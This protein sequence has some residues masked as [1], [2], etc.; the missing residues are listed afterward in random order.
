VIVGRWGEVPVCWCISSQGSTSH[1]VS[2]REECERLEE[3]V[4]SR[5]W[6]PVVCR[7]EEYP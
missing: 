5:A 2:S 3:R 4:R 7:Y 1:I 6:G